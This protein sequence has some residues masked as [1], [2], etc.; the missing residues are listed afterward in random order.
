MKKILFTLGLLLICT[1]V[2]TSCSV[3]SEK[4]ALHAIIIPKLE[5]GE[6]SGDFPGEAQLFYERYCADCI[7]MMDRLISLR[8]I[9]NMDLFMDGETPES[10]WG[11][12]SS[13]SEKVEN[14]N[15]ETLD[16]FEPAMHNLYDTGS[17]VIDAIL[18]GTL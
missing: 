6:M 11:E 17:I 15:T 9:V 4:T 5:I 1:L 12:Y 16:V 13:F 7:D 18:E 10:T 3:T 14:D 2:F 8:V